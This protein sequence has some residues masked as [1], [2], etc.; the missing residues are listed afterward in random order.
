MLYKNC[1]LQFISL[2]LFAG[3]TSVSRNEI[4]KKIEGKWHQVGG[5]GVMA[6]MSVLIDYTF[7]SKKEFIQEVNAPGD[8]TV[9]YKYWPAK[10]GT[11]RIINDSIYLYGDGLFEKAFYSA[12]IL[13][14][15]ERKFALIDENG[16]LDYERNE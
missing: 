7:T 11:F 8:K 16:E 4:E 3:C 2:I 12:K 9:I 5:V 6:D 15:N 1:K 14:S 13:F 10:R